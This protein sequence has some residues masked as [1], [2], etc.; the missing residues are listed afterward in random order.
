MVGIQ[1]PNKKNI[2]LRIYPNPS[3]GVFQIESTIAI[4]TIEVYNSMGQLI[5]TT[6]TSDKIDLSTFEKGIY[7]ATLTT[8]KGVVNRKLIVK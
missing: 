5:L 4:N 6:K 7:Y 8:G 2:N 1:N 3:E